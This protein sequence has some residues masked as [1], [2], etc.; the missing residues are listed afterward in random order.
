MR[1]HDLPDRPGAASRGF[2]LIELLVVI[3]II[4]VL[5]GMVVG[6]TGMARARMYL[7]KTKA[8]IST[9]A[10]A[11]EA[12]NTLTGVYPGAGI[13]G[14]ATDNPEALFRA[15]YTGNPKLGGSRDNHLADWP[16]EQ[17]GKWPGAYQQVYDQPTEDELDYSSTMK[18]QCVFL[19]PW[20][21]AF[22]FVEFDSRSQGDRQLASGQLKAKGGQGFAIWSDGPNATNEWGQGDDIT[23]WS[24]GTSRSSKGKTK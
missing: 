7:T 17:L 9:I 11:L 19:D 12:Y 24:E 16:M 5:A 15:L 6:I 23:S 10:V 4:G 1:T 14:K 13:S 8:N 22:H 20:G 21:R 3:A 18:S 2:T